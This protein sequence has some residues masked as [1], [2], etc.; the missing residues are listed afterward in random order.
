MGAPLIGVPMP[1]KSFFTTA[2]AL[3]VGLFV[4][5]PCWAISTVA[6]PTNSDGTPRFTEPNAPHT[7]T[8]GPGQTTTT[9]GSG[10]FSFGI[11]T[12][13]RDG[14]GFPNQSSY[15]R[16]SYNSGFPNSGFSDQGF[17]NSQGLPQGFPNYQGFPNSGPPTSYA[18]SRPGPYWA[19]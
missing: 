6:G 4:A 14:L 15:D 10:T 18:P 1:C 16:G 11:T 7:F 3:A 5:T 19:H 13:Q 12:S 2:S 17:P 9:F 8:S